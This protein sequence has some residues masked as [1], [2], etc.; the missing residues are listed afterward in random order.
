[1]DG[2]AHAIHKCEWK[3]MDTLQ[4]EACEKY[5]EITGFRETNPYAIWHRRLSDHRPECSNCGHL[6]SRRRRRR[7]TDMINTKNNQPLTM[8]AIPGPGAVTLR[9]WHPPSPP[10]Y[11]KSAKG[12]VSP[13]V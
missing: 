6:F 2:A 8:A 10:F 11:A 13:P 12:E 3:A 5:F 1:V 4:F 9:M 7:E